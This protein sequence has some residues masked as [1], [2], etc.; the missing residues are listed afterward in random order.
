MVCMIFKNGIPAKTPWLLKF[1]FKYR[2]WSY[3][4]G[5]NCIY[6]TF[7]DGPTPGVTDWVLDTLK[8]FDAKATFF[9]IGK[10]VA[11]HGKLYNRILNEGHG[12]GNHTNNHVNGWKTNTRD[13][14]KN[15]SKASEYINSKLFRPPYGRTSFKQSAALR[16]LGYKIIMWDV[17]AMD[18][19]KTLSSDSCYKN[20]V[21][22][23]E[24]GSIIVFH[25]SVKAS[26]NLKEILPR[27]LTDFKHKGF[28][29][30]IIK[31]SC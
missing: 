26:K 27:V 13:Y 7:D 17:L 5:Q 19:D 8:K 30:K 31:E 14:L 16:K 18:W 21:N 24:D 15:V 22:Y 20:V 12:I 23:T 4:K 6:L 28:S 10:N 25:D 11:A 3:P 29:F 1:F 2:I 9:C